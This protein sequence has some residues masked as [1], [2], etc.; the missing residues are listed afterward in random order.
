MSNGVDG[1]DMCRPSRLN[2]VVTGGEH[3]SQLRCSCHNHTPFE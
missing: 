1:V 3:E 2:V